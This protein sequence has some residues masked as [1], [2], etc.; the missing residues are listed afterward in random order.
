MHPLTRRS[1][2]PDTS[3]NCLRYIGAEG[4]EPSS[5]GY[6][7]RI[8]PLDHAPPAQP[9]TSVSRAGVEPA[10]PTGHRGLSA[11]CLPF[12]PPGHHGSA[13][14]ISG[15]EPECSALQAA[16][17][18]TTARSASRPLRFVR[19]SNPSRWRDKPLAS[20]EA[21]RT[22]CSR[23]LQRSGIRRAASAPKQSSKFVW[24]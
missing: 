18:T 11:A 15:I 13:V 21:S 7:P 8:F 10:R 19:E 6:Q 2:A 4:I 9:C 23:Q 12:H 16:A 5:H 24:R 22:R 3:T 14:P 17:W 1:T 20:P